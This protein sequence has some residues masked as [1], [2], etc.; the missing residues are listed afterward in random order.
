VIA[1]IG[2]DIVEIAR[3]ARLLER[4]GERFVRRVL[5]PAEWDEYRSSASRERYLASRFAAKEAFGKAFGTGIR[6]PVLLTRIS[7]SHDPLGRPMLELAPE[8]QALTA[9]RGIRA[10]HITLTHER[11]VAC[12][13]VVLER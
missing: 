11:S 7:V 8:L 1:G 13:V 5:G 4:Y 3:I 9:S 2:A 12:A 6:D 10:Q